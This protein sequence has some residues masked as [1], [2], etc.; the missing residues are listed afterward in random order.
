MSSL[1]HIG[2][3]VPKRILAFEDLDKAGAA[4][5]AIHIAQCLGKEVGPANRAEDFLEL[6]EAAEGML[7]IY[8]TKHGEQ[9]F[10][11]CCYIQN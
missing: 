4:N 3:D 6:A 5:V 9:I 10:L 8:G 7:A 2:A 1:A 11:S